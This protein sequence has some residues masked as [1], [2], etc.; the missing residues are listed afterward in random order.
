MSQIDGQIE[1]K[2]DVVLGPGD[3]GLELPV[4]EHPQPVQSY[5]IL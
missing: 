1:V 3:E 2:P 5:H 4:A